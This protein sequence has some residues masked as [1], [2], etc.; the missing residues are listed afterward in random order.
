MSKLEDIPKESIFR[1]PENYFVEL[2][3]R[4]QSRISVRKK[5]SSSEKHLWSYALRYA[6]PL[7]VIAAILVY[8]YYP[9]PDA[10]SILA[11]VETADIVQY[12]QQESALTT[13]DVLDNIDFK[14]ED[15]EAIENEVYDL[16]TDAND[17]D[18]ELEFNTL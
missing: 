6:L 14:T 8:N 2:P 18:L 12:L 5:T 15:V 4:I 7:A 16:G 10:E 17:Q 1:V 9:E 3:S 13:E 11:T